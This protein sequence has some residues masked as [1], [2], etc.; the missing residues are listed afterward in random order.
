MEVLFLKEHV[1]QLESSYKARE[2]SSEN[3]NLADHVSSVEDN[4]QLLFE[5]KEKEIFSLRDTISE[6]QYHMMLQCQE[7]EHEMENILRQRDTELQEQCDQTKKFDAETQLLKRTLEDYL[8]QQKKRDA[9]TDGILKERQAELERQCQK[10]K[11]LATE[12]DRLRIDLENCLQRKSEIE[13]LLKQ[14][15]R[16]LEAQCSETEKFATE[17]DQLREELQGFLQQQK[18]REAATNG[19]LKQREVELETQRQEIESLTREVEKLALQLEQS[20]TETKE[21]YDYE[22]QYPDNVTESHSAQMVES[23]NDIERLYHQ[24]QEELQQVIVDRNQLATQLFSIQNEWEQLVNSL[25]GKHNECENYY[26]QLQQLSQ[27]SGEQIHSL[28][29]ELSRVQESEQNIQHS[30]QHALRH[31][32]ILLE[33]EETVLSK[34]DDLET[35]SNLVTTRKKDIQQTRFDVSCTLFIALESILLHFLLIFKLIIMVDL[36]IQ[37]SD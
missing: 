18:D 16:E 27:E 10:T 9:E 20:V 17:S 4:S 36:G 8:Q 25:Q 11:D 28:Q 19:L 5:S 24:T 30:Y 15:N 21:C 13:E 29:T 23:R 1:Q 33:V 3:K 34:K 37:F 6:L 7:K 31:L 2:E 32:A 22:Q 35:V 26:Q 14:R 12:V